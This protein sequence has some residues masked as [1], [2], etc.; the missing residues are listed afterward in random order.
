G[1][2][3]IRGRG[4]ALLTRTFPLYPAI[5]FTPFVFL[6]LLGSSP[7]SDGNGSQSSGRIL[8]GG[9]GHLEADFRKTYE[10][11]EGKRLVHLVQSDVTFRW[12]PKVG[13]DRIPLTDQWSR[14]GEQR[15]FVFAVTQRLLRVDNVTGPNEL[16]S[17]AIEWA[18]DVGDRTPSGSPYLDPLS[19]FARTLRDQ[20]DI[21][22]GKITRKRD[23]ASDMFARFQYRLTPKWN[24]SGETLLD[25][26]DGTFTHAAIS[27]EW[28]RDQDTR[29]LLEYRISRDL[30]EDIHGRFAV[31]PVKFLGLQANTNYSIKSG[32]LTEGSVTVTLYPRSDCWS[33]GLVALRKTNPN[34]T[35]FKVLFSLKGIGSQTE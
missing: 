32:R 30:S 1:D 11:G 14:I 19:P 5:S 15:Q 21:A 3:E 6:D 17:L 34:E 24:L 7:T 10:T 27:T 12:V 8:P 13:Q 35:G 4:A 33:V 16:A 23:A 2:R 26:G 29:A 9:G 18:L 31:R 25:T 22:A 28:K 20:I